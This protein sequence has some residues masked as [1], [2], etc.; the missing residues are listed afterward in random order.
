[1][2]IGR[3]RRKLAELLQVSFPYRGQ[4]P[5]IWRPEWLYPATGAWRTNYMLDCWRWEGFAYYAKQDG[6][7][8]AAWSVGSYHPMS[9]LIKYK[10]LYVSDGEIYPTTTGH[11]GG[12]YA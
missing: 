4:L 9:E 11:E 12:R 1:M 3:T 10:R 2:A 6:S 5:L 8:S 7:L